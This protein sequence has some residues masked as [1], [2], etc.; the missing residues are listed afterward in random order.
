MKPQLKII[1]KYILPVTLFIACCLAGC[2]FA[3]CY[4]AK[5]KFNPE[6]GY[7][8]AIVGSYRAYQRSGRWGIYNSTTKAII[9]P[10][11]YTSVKSVGQDLFGVQYGGK[12]GI[13]D[14]VGTQITPTE[15]D[16]VLKLT[17]RYIMLEQNGVYGWVSDTGKLIQT[18][19]Y[20]SLST[21]DTFIF[22]ACVTNGCGIVR[23]SDGRVLKP[24]KYPGVF[25]NS[26]LYGY[27]LYYSGGGYGVIDVEDAV[28]A[29]PKYR[30]IKKVTKDAIYITDGGEK[31]GLLRMRDGKQIA[32]PVYDKI[33]DM[34]QPGFYKVK[35]D[36]KW[37]AVDYDGNMVFKCE[38]GPLEIN[39]K[40]KNYPNNQ[41]YNE[42]VTYNNYYA[43][44]LNAYYSLEYLGYDNSSVR[45]L[46]KNVLSTENTYQDLKNKANELIN[47]YG[48][49]RSKL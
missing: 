8:K 35:K 34:S 24:L 2:N 49:D 16:N 41:K 14:E 3:Y 39:K 21:I 9:T 18:P 20:K 44:Y 45:K 5:T 42:S 4:V 1:K 22:N 13:V 15:W 27:L 48:I 17:N 28:I 40:V 19:I 32:A 26:G 31:L 23:A 33:E 37:G 30:G 29:P 11:V 25:K 6:D 38:Y 46:L 7:T 36:N 47:Q 12:W 43:D 10:P